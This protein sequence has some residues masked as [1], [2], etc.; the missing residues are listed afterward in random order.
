M[1]QDLLLA[2][3]GGG[4][5]ILFVKFL[6]ERHDKK[7]EKAEEES[8]EDDYIKKA[9]KKMEKDTLRTQLLLMIISLPE[10]KKEIMTLAQRYF[11]KPP[12]GLDGNWYM[13]DIF[14]KWLKEKGH[15]NPEWFDKGG[16]S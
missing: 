12:E 16:V 6:I 7:V 13:T 14:K 9:L 8:K 2:I 1:N 3:L 15:S 11:S 4:N 10:E 5:F